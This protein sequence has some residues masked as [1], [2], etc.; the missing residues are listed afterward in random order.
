M[1]PPEGSKTRPRSLYRY[2]NAYMYPSRMERLSKFKSKLSKLV[3]RE[4]LG[5]SGRP[6]GSAVLTYSSN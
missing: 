2:G 3:S 5:D 4:R 6:L 1:T